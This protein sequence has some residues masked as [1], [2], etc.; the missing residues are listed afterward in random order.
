MI[1]KPK[2]R[3]KEEKSGRRALKIRY[4]YLIS[5]IILGIIVYWN[6]RE[7]PIQDNF[8]K[9]AVWLLGMILGGFAVKTAGNII[10]LIGGK[11]EKNRY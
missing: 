11:D 4:K 3:K 7:I 1:S 10:C 8:V 9:M 2:M 6:W 5:F